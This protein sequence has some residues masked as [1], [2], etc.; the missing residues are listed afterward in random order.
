[1]LGTGFIGWLSIEIF[2]GEMQK[3]HGNDIVGF[4]TKAIAAVE[5]LVKE[6]REA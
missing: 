3:K 1:M 5:T 6:A 4:V 2:D